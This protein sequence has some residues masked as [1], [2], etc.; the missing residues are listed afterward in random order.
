MAFTIGFLVQDDFPLLSLASAVE[1]LRAANALTGREFFRW[2]YMSVSDEDTQAS[3]GL[4]VRPDPA[5]KQEADFDLLFVCAGNNAT[6]F[7]RQATFAWLRRLDRMGKCLGGISGG[8]YILARAGLLRGRRC[9]LH[10]EHI[11]AF[12][13]EFPDIDLRRTLF[14]LDDDRYT[15]AGGIASLDMM[16]ALIAAKY[17]PSAA[18]AASEWLLQT[19][20][21]VGDIYQR[22]TAR[23]RFGVSH[24]GLV[25]AL[26]YI[27]A[28]LDRSFDRQ[29]LADEL[30]LSLRHIERLFAVH[31]KTTI[32]HHA[33]KLRLDRARSL[34]RE[35]TM[36]II[37]VALAAGFAN[38]SHF[39]RVYR[40]R[41]GVS[42]SDA[43]RRDRATGQ[44][45]MS[46]AG[47]DLDEA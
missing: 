18:Q 31:L 43:R 36:P 28:N 26:E 5:A 37:E 47:S 25:K 23:D 9:T 22:M 39:A 4:I 1:P 20:V 33:L 32:Q 11:P 13:E 12:R 35:T 10:W 34:L 3:S 27:D 42:P 21:R 19:H 17:S 29:A 8:P 15:C 46:H 6:H 40:K 2:K 45:S 7:H 30:G 24:P 41:F 16:N 14:E 44:A 38:A